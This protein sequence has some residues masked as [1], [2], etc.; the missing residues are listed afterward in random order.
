MKQKTVIW[1]DNRDDMPRPCG[2][3]LLLS[4]DGRLVLRDAQGMEVGKIANTSQQATL[5]PCLIQAISSSTTQI[6][7]NLAQ[8]P[9]DSPILPY[10]AYWKINTFKEVKAKAKVVYRLT[11]D[12]DGNLRLYSHSL[13]HDSNWAVEWF[14]VKNKCAPI[15]LCGLNS[16]CVLGDDEEP[17]YACLPGFDFTD[18][19]RRS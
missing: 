3:T 4:S 6:N 8:Y 16:Y 5:L 14:S 12:A 17:T 2:T 15:G 18:Q 19:H 9:A 11:I 13:V 1:T 7:G 10:Y